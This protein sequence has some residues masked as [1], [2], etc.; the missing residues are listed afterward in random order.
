MN[1]T[2][3]EKENTVDPHG[4]LEPSEFV[5][6]TYHGGDTKILFA[7]NSIARH[8]INEKLGWFGDWGMAASSEDKDF[9]HQ[10]VRMLED[11][12]MKVDYC[13]AQVAE[14]EFRFNEDL[15]PLE[16]MYANA[17]DFAAD[18]VIIRA[19]ENMRRCAAM[20]NEPIEKWKPYFDNMIRFFCSNPNAKVI[21]TDSFHPLEER[22]RFIREICQERGYTF[23]KISDLGTDEKY[24]ATGLYR[25]KAVCRHPGDLGMEEIAKRLVALI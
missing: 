20:E 18:I 4:Q 16:E 12:G 17:K 24:M 7:G 3:Y 19:C 10:T 13:V 1:I 14:W 2:I 23:C 22:D 15:A 8:E 6:F 25:S 9:V 5:S 11:R 21:V